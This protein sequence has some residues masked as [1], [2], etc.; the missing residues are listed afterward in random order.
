MVSGQILGVIL[1]RKL[2]GNGAEIKVGLLLHRPPD[3]VKPGGDAQNCADHQSKGARCKHIVDQIPKQHPANDTP[4]QF[5][6][7]AV[8]NIGPGVLAVIVFG[9]G[10]GLG[11]LNF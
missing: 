4:N 10:G 11:R 7:C 2:A 8:P 9:R 6:A 3:A 1:A 5:P